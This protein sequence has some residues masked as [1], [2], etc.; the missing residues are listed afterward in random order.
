[1]GDR[2]RIL[3]TGATSGI[4]YQLGRE[5]AKRSHVVYFTT[6]TEKQLGT[7]KRKIREDGFSALCFKMDVTTSDIELVDQLE[8]DCLISHAGIG[9]GGSLLYMS[10]EHLKKNYEVNIFSSFRLIQRVYRNMEKQGKKGKIFVTSSMAA[11]LPFPF[12]GC[13]TSSKAAITMLCKTIRKE[14][15]YL[16]SDITISVIEPGAYHTGFNQVMIDNKDIYLDSDNM[17]YKHRDSINRLMRNMFCL[18][19]KDDCFDLIRKVVV[20]IE[21]KHSKFMIRRP[22]FASVFLKIYFAL[23]Y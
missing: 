12:L 15:K 16:K 18:L 14:L 19:E 23:F 8:I 17:I 1:M 6:H 13:Y 20:E 3:I 10:I 11:Y 4:A 22:I 2:M 9:L 21:K 7:L 5:L